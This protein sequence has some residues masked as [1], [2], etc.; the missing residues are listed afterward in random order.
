MAWLYLLIAGIFEV[1]WAI[2]MKY[3]QGFT[4]L[5]PSLITIAGMVLSI[6]FLSLATKTLP[7]GTAYAVWTGIGALGAILLG[8]ILFNEPRDPGRLLFL[9]LILIGIIGLKLTTR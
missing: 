4:R 2:G 7:I 9:S 5:I 1:V 8:M 6:T 3:T